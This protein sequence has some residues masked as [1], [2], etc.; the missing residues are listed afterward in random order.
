M[1]SLFINLFFF[2]S[3]DWPIIDIQTRVSGLITNAPFILNVDCDM[4]VNNPKTV[5]HALSILLDS[6]GEKEVA[7]AQCPQQFY[8][9]LK[10]DPFG[11]QMT[12][13]FK[14]II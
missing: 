14:V 3:H 13:L 11:N 10:D 12:I 2:H 8:A 7:F 6:K 1:Y 9:T 4:F 5:L